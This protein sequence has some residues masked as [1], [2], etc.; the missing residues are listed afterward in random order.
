VLFDLDDTLYP[1][2]RF[3]VSGFRAVAA[4]LEWT[5][6]IERHRVFA[7][8]THAAAGPDRGLELQ[9]VAKRFSLP[10]DIVPELVH[11]IRGHQP[12]IRLPRPSALA[13]R[14]LRAGWRLAIV[15]NGLPE[16]QARKVAAL[17]LVDAVDTIVFASE[18]GTGRG[19][20]D[21]APFLA[22][23]QQL[24]VSPERSVFVGDDERCD[25][26]G[27]SGVGMHTVLYR[28]GQPVGGSRCA[29]AVVD[30]LLN[31]PQVASALVG[32]V[33]VRGI[34]HVA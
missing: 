26:V 23:L 22:A 27:A 20:P 7:A 3:V 5:R 6:G 1:R 31:V 32:A 15:T 33:G 10:D 14:R 28:P 30:T 13:L 24:D 9:A 21:P 18:H 19:K 34:R 2:C 16:T 11:V 17:G 8:L 12:T 29:D 25:L 4:H